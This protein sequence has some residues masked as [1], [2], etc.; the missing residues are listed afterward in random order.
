LKLRNIDFSKQYRTPQRIL[1]VPEQLLGFIN[2]E[3]IE[4]TGRHHVAKFAI[5]EESPPPPSP[6][7]K[8]NAPMKNQCGSD[9][10]VHKKSK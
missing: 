8:R 10:S 7:R 1:A 4:P 2:A 3:V 9:S 6:P 5:G